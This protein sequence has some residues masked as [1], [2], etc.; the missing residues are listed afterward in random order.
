VNIAVCRFAVLGLF[1]LAAAVPLVQAQPTGKP[2]LTSGAVTPNPATLGGEVTLV[3]DFQRTVTPSACDLVLNWGDGQQGNV[4][5]GEM[6]HV[7]YLHPYRTLGRHTI[8]ASGVGANACLGSVQLDVVVQAPPP[9]R[10]ATPPA[11]ANAA[12]AAA[13]AARGAPTA[14]IKGTIGIQVDS[15][16]SFDG[17]GSTSVPPGRALAFQWD[18]RDGTTATGAKVSHRFHVAKEYSV[19]LVVTDGVTRSAPAVSQVRVAPPPAAGAPK[20]P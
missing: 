7:K 3:L 12:L 4:S 2:Q 6:Q 8:R 1:S 16:A 14:V 5:S 20:R 11:V 13:A 15:L 10:D 19:T 9:P 18:F 17:S